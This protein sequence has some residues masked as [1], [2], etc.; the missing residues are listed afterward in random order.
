MSTDRPPAQLFV[1]QDESPDDHFY[2]EP[3][4]VTHIDDATILAVRQVLREY[5]KAEYRVLDLM[6]SWISNLPEEIHYRSVSALGMNEEELRANPRLDDYVVHDLNVE[7]ALPYQNESFD[8]VIITVSIQ[9]LIRPYEVFASIARV[10]SPAGICIVN[11]SH[12]LFPTKAIYAFHTLPPHERCQLVSSY[13]TESGEFEDPSYYDRSPPSADP[14]WVV[15][16]RKCSS[17]A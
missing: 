7:P 4:F 2:V 15:M 12:K 13:F 8:A 5:L 16:A 11:M 17:A 1:R 3:R 10:L 14:L 6:S 9:Y